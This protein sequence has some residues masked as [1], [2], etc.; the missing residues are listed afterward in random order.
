[1][2]LSADIMMTG[3]VQ[4][5]WPK[6][7]MRSSHPSVTISACVQGFTEGD[8]TESDQFLVNKSAPERPWL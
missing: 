2:S 6:A 5:L 1:M 3:Y 4:A 7:V 8:P